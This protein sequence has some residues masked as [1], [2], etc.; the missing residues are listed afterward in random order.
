[1]QERI[2]PSPQLLGL[3]QAQGG[4]VSVGQAET[5]GLGRH[6]RQRLLRSGQWQRLEGPVLVVHPFAVSWEGQAWAGILIGGREARLSRAAAAHLHGLT[7]EP[8][9]LIDVLVHSPVPDR[10]PWVFHRDQAGVRSP[11]SPG[12]PPRTTIED[13]VL[14]LCEGT[15]PKELVHW[16]TQA[17]QTRRTSSVR[18]LAA[19]EGRARHGRRALLRELLG[20]VGQGAESP[21][22]LR[23]LR[24]VERAHGLPKAERQ[25][26]NRR[27]H[28]RDV[29]YEQ[30]GV[31]VELDGRIGHEGL[32]RF[33]DM[34]RDNGALLDGEITLRY[35]SADVSE[36]AC[37]VA[38]QVF[39][40]LRSRG[41]D[42]QL[43]RCPRCLVVPEQEVWRAS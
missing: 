16:L 34:S 23:Y 39:F 37:T 41:Y 40:M 10:H 6:P 33:R 26:S 30:F 43:R 35:G 12:A 17:V 13:T 20:D 19:L 1:M 25:Q 24:D 36:E 31:V 5:L 42:G 11:R 38:R 3:A 32:G 7:A 22:E 29:R 2:D 21:L 14:D 15:E 9:E 27:R 18:L 8:P 28:R 4:V